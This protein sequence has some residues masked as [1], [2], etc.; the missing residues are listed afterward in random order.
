MSINPKEFLN[1]TQE[2]HAF[3]I[4]ICEV[5]CPWPP[6]FKGMPTQ[7]S[8]DLKTEFHYYMLGRAIGVYAWLVLAYIIKVL[9]T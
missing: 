4:G 1:T 9:F 7:D 5:I 2:L 6:Y 3:T 8:V